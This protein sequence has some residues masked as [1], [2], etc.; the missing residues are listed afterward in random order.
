M[1]ISF[2]QEKDR[3][4]ARLFTRYPVLL[5]RWAQ[6]AD[7]ATFSDT[8]WAPLKKTITASRIALITT[9]GVHL[10]SQKPFDMLN[11][12]G[13]ASYREIPFDAPAEQLH[14]SHNHYDHSDADRDINIIFPLQHLQRLAELGEIGSV[15]RRHFSL[16]GHI[17]GDLIEVLIK[18]T[19]PGIIAAL[20]KD[21]V[22]AVLLTP[23]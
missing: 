21:A 2:K 23:A 5:R 18:E 17:S 20:G 9:G 12:S 7:I 3:W 8:P 10:R 4:L 6:R 15:N 19:V 1:N 22:D 13:D 16:M 11:P 14:I